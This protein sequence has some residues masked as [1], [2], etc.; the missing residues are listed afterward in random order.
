MT[1]DEKTEM[2]VPNVIPSL[3]EKLL[4]N[5]VHWNIMRWQDE[6]LS[7]VIRTAIVERGVM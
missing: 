1:S 5:S 2:P 7:E 3:L 4:S 6:E